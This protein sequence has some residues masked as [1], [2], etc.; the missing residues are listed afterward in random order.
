MTPLVRFVGAG[1]ALALLP[2]VEGFLLA[3]AAAELVTA[4]AYW[5][6]LARTGDLGLLTRRPPADRR[7]LADNP[8]LV[9]FPLS[10]NTSSTPSLSTKHVPLLLVGGYVELGRASCRERV[11]QYVLNSVGPVSL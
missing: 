7:L 5:I 8:G 2:T 9:R 6:I 3:W 11:C 10:T 4:G 1:L